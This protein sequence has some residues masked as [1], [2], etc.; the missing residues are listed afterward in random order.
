MAN[1]KDAG[2]SSVKSKTEK[3]TLPF[4]QFK[5]RPTAVFVD[6]IMKQLRETAQ[7]ELIEGLFRNP[8]PKDVEFFI[9]RPDVVIDGKKRPEG[10]HAPCPM[11]SPNKSRK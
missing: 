5:D 1:G 10:D 4:R 3:P 6:S 11:C 7:P 8:I 2:A 9:I